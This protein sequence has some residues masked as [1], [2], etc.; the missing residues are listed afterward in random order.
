MA[1]IPFIPIDESRELA[2]D[3]R[4]LFEDLAASLD[5][6][7]RAYSG[8]CHPLL[9]VYETDAAVEVIVDVSGVPCDALRVLFRDGA[10]IIAGE[11][12]PPPPSDAQTFHLVEREFGR[13]ARAVRV[14]G[15]FDVRNARATLRE[16]ELS[17]RLPKL[18]ERRGQAHR[19]AITPD[20]PA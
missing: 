8:E 19:I 13:F 18:E 10:V 3:V 2:E 12:A 7:Q 14:H 5:H 11:K 4:A 20:Q 1:Q 16:G 17:V 15:A 6:Q 9:D